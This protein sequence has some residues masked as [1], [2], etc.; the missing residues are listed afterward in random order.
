[1]AGPIYKT[2]CRR[3]VWRTRASIGVLVLASFVV[4][5]G[6]GAPAV[7]QVVTYPSY[8]C[9]TN[10]YSP[11]CPNYCVNAK[12]MGYCFET[13]PVYACVTYWWECGFELDAR[14]HVDTDS[15]CGGVLTCETETL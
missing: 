11:Y 6:V 10:D 3:G 14:T 2:Q 15:A 13:L 8:Y 1:M 7:P 5:L 9:W 4:V 12:E